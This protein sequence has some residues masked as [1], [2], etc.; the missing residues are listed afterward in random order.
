MEIFEVVFDILYLTSV[1]AISLII[2]KRGFSIKSKAL[3]VFG[4]MGFLLGF[5]DSFH[6]VPRIVAHLTTGMDSYSK[7]LGVGKLITG[8]TMTV[9]YYLLLKYYE[10]V[11]SVKSKVVEYSIISLMIIRFVLLALPGNDWVNNGNDLFYGILRNI[12]FAIIGVLIVVQFL[13]KKHQIESNQFK[14]IGIWV[15]V[16]FVCYAIVVVGSGFI[17][18][19][20]A[21]MMPKTVAYFLIIIIGFKYSEKLVK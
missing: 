11:T 15:I 4:V 21:F 16:S 12:P 9:F 1:I 13:S 10:L 6:L 20:G 3:I 7:A 2:V 8:I 18:A 17:P 5:G 14:W 19:L